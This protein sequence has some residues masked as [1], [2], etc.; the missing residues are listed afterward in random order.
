[1]LKPNVVKPVAKIL[2]V[3]AVVGGLACKIYANI[4]T[5][6]SEASV[7]LSCQ[8]PSAALGSMIFN[9]RGINPLNPLDHAFEEHSSTLAAWCVDPFTEQPK[10]NITVTY[11]YSTKHCEAPSA[12]EMSDPSRHCLDIDLLSPKKGE[13]PEVVYVPRE[14][15]SQES[16]VFDIENAIIAGTHS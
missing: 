6:P 16:A 12:E 10:G 3:A 13:E 5:R 7:A 1:M 11:V 2:A 8:D 4:P 9:D 14:N 15:G